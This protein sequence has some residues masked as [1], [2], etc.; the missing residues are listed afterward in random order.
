MS[1]EI[2]NQSSESVWVRERDKNNNNNKNYGR[3][4]WRQEIE[5]QTNISTSMWR[6]V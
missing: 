1:V 2:E 3:L 6:N 5:F 4:I